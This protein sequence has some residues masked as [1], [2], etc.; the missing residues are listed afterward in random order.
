MFD[1]ALKNV[2]FCVRI[3]KS[4][5]VHA[6]AH[7]QHSRIQE[8][9]QLTYYHSFSFGNEQMVVVHMSANYT[10]KVKFYTNMTEISKIVDSASEVN[11]LNFY[12]CYI[13]S[14]VHFNKNKNFKKAVMDWVDSSETYVLEKNRIK[15]LKDFL[16][17]M[18]LN[19]PPLPPPDVPSLSPNPSNN[20]LRLLFIDSS[21]QNMQILAIT[22]EIAR[23]MDA[24]A[25]SDI[26]RKF[27]MPF[28]VDHNRAFSRWGISLH[29]CN[30]DILHFSGH[31]HHTLYQLIDT[32][33]EPILREAVVN[34][35]GAYSS[36]NNTGRLKMVVFNACFSNILADEMVQHV[37]IA[38]GMMGRIPDAM[39]MNFGEQIYAQIAQGITIQRAFDIA[40]AQINITES[41]LIRPILRHHNS[42]D[43]TQYVL[44]PG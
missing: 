22:Q 4:Y 23:M 36:R 8:R 28:T 16:N 34:L 6:P 19:P 25:L 12:I 5:V 44:C 3:N 33:G 31:G 35:L 42:I 11:L 37:D 20:L 15:Y 24:I 7:A 41:S 29:H 39:A 26:R 14:S 2:S 1:G 38:I 40:L 30:P 13:A 27:V 9:H 17:E 18:K 10:Y 43:P 32:N 21:P